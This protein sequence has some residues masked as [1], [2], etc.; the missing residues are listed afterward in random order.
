METSTVSYKQDH[1]ILVLK[2]NDSGDLIW[3]E[4]IGTIKDDSEPTITTDNFG[5]LY[6]AGR[7]KGNFA[8]DNKLAK[9][10]SSCDYFV[11]KMITTERF[12][13]KKLLMVQKT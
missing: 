5:N 11:A 10:G 6:L 12:I 3:S 7:T 13:L 4:Q 2:F 1:D 8:V 9:L